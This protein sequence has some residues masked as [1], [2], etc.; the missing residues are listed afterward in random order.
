MHM[1]INHP[2]E[3]M[4]AR[5]K[6]FESILIKIYTEWLD[7]PDSG[8][9][10]DITRKLNIWIVQ[11]LLVEE[12]ILCFENTLNENLIREYFQ[13][14]ISSTKWEPATYQVWTALPPSL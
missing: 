13:N 9:L 1:K 10:T 4:E 6:E 12:T 8:G 3:R 14:S 7:S 2:P 5:K 11:S